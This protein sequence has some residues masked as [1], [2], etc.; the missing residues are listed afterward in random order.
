MGDDDDE[1]SGPGRKPA[2]TDEEILGVF[3]NSSDPVLTATEV[4]DELSMSRRAIFDRLRDLEDQGK[5]KSKKVGARGAIWW[6]PGYTNTTKE[7]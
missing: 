7:N 5:L 1:R 6:Y 2:V 3:L 4:A